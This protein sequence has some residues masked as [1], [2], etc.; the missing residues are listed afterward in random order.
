MSW[1]LSRTS[2]CLEKPERKEIKQVNEICFFHFYFVHNT[3]ANFISCTNGNNTNTTQSEFYSTH[4]YYSIICNGSFI[5]QK[6]FFKSLL[7]K[8][9]TIYDHN[10]LKWCLQIVRDCVLINWY[11][12]KH[13]H[14]NLQT[15]SAD[16]RKPL[17]FFLLTNKARFRRRTFHE[18]NL[19][20][21][22]KYMKSSAS[23]SIR[24]ACLKMERLSRSFRLTPAGNLTL[25]SDFGTALI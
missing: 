23:E 1:T 17:R 20:H 13:F 19:I 22:I 16:Y 24:N 21:W 7:V 14:Y 15:F 6:H 25:W 4:S 9:G 5:Y 12:Q 10:V 8:M 18:P 11:L 2:C 3:G